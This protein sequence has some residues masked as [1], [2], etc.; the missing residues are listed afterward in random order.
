MCDLEKTVLQK[1][2]GSLELLALVLCTGAGYY[3]VCYLTSFLFKFCCYL[4]A[5]FRA[6]Y[7]KFCESLI[8]P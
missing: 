4:G 7:R 1:V 3:P 5:T 8:H 2:T 6:I